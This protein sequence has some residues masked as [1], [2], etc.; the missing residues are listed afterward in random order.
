MGHSLDRL[1]SASPA[2]THTLASGSGSDGGGKSSADGGR[3]AGPMGARRL[4]VTELVVTPEG[5]V[6]EAREL[7][8]VIPKLRQLRAPSRLRV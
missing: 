1:R 8:D 3:P 7:Y 4:E 5:E 6:W 2:S